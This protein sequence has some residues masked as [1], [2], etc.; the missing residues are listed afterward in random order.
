MGNGR[1]ARVLI[2]EN[3][4]R[5]GD[6]ENRGLSWTHPCPLP[7]PPYIR[8]ISPAQAL[9]YLNG[10]EQGSFYSFG[11]S[12]LVFAGRIVPVAS[13]LGATLKT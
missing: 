7:K 12:F 1:F 3:R 5:S 10:L 6:Q 13:P 4:A 11:L 9:P 8:L 2:E